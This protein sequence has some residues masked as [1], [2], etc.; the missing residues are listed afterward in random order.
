MISFIKNKE[1]NNDACVVIH[2]HGSFMLV[3]TGNKAIQALSLAKAAPAMRRIRYNDIGIFEV[4]KDYTSVNNILQAWTNRIINVSDYNVIVKE[5]QAQ[6]SNCGYNI[7]EVYGVKLNSGSYMMDIGFELKFKE[8]SVYVDFAFC[9][10]QGYGQEAVGYDFT[11]NSFIYKSNVRRNCGYF[12]K[13]QNGEFVFNNSSIPFIVKSIM[14]EANSRNISYTPSL[15]VVISNVYSNMRDNSFKVLA[16][17]NNSDLEPV[18]G[19]SLLKAA[20]IAIKLR[21]EGAAIMK[22]ITTSSNTNN[23]TN[24]GTA[25]I[26]SAD[27]VESIGDLLL[28]TTTATGLLSSEYEFLENRHRFLAMAWPDNST[29]LRMCHAAGSSISELGNVTCIDAKTMAEVT[30]NLMSMQPSWSNNHDMHKILDE[31]GRTIGFMSCNGNF[32]IYD[33]LDSIKKTSLD[34]IEIEDPV[35]TKANISN[36]SVDSLNYKELVNEAE[37]KILY[38]RSKVASIDLDDVRQNILKIDEQVSRTYTTLSSLISSQSIANAAASTILKAVDLILSMPIKEAYTGFQ[39]GIL[40]EYFSFQLTSDGGTIVSIKNKRH[41]LPY[42]NRLTVD[43]C[44]KTYI[45]DNGSRNGDN[46]GYI[47][48][49]STYS[50][51]IN[52]LHGKKLSCVEK[53]F[54][55]APRQTHGSGKS[56]KVVVELTKV[57]P[58]IVCEYNSFMQQ[59]QGFLTTLLNMD[60][61]KAARQINQCVSRVADACDRYS[62]QRTPYQDKMRQYFA[63][64]KMLFFYTHVLNMAKNHFTYENGLGI[65]SDMSYIKKESEFNEFEIQ[66]ANSITGG[67]AVEDRFINLESYRESLSNTIIEINNYQGKIKKAVSFYSSI[68]E[69]LKSYKT[70]NEENEENNELRN[71][72]P[73]V[74]IIMGRK[75]KANKTDKETLETA[76]LQVKEAPT[77]IEVADFTYTVELLNKIIEEKDEDFLDSVQQL[78]DLKTIITEQNDKISEYFSLVDKLRKDIQNELK[79]TTLTFNNKPLTVNENRFSIDTDIAKVEYILDECYIK[80]EDSMKIKV[81][82]EDIN[83]ANANLIYKQTTITP[84]VIELKDEAFTGD[85]NLIAIGS[86]SYDIRN[87]LQHNAIY[88]NLPYH[89]MV[90]AK[91]SY[92]LLGYNEENDDVIYKAIKDKYNIQLA[93]FYAGYVSKT[94]N[95][96]SII[97]SLIFAAASNIELFATTLMAYQGKK[98]GILLR[99]KGLAVNNLSGIR[100]VSQNLVL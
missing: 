79:K 1:F 26:L 14:P 95:V 54:E 22:K 37:N 20:D 64:A 80:Y 63:D 92:N 93:D 33:S 75:I 100:D 73:D 86:M 12:S 9:G 24:V 55:V 68:I 48:V 17:N 84:V 88:K 35:F 53:E 87:I 76:D 90:K 58:R 7:V 81:N 18:I 28:L 99:D 57:E 67:I 97:S 46:S 66:A 25:K 42:A 39:A 23:L 91:I 31:G 10:T 16:I 40:L 45:A 62:A 70:R 59:I 47:M 15:D 4:D 69:Q 85:E 41:L 2:R 61:M 65:S 3:V 83:I 44:G 82:L 43:R 78:I 72:D 98:L 21:E 29:Q 77:T 89:K 11:T 36:I 8:G 5:I 6:L 60:V 96:E 74:K 32:P 34:V 94:E 38:Y 13:K 49:G 19:G 52:D 71:F 56:E 30:E 50:N 51:A 27:V